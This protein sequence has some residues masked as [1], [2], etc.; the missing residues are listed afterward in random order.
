MHTCVTCTCTMYTYARRMLSYRYAHVRAHA[1]VHRRIR[2]ATRRLRSSPLDVVQAHSFWLHTRMYV[3]VYRRKCTIHCTV[4]KM[5]IS[6]SST[7]HRFYF[8][9]IIPRSPLKYCLYHCLSIIIYSIDL[10]SVEALFFSLVCM[11]CVRCVYDSLWNFE[12]LMVRWIEWNN[13][14]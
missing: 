1:L 6:D 14:K 11:I 12:N 4:Y 13:G 9:G 10:V 3:W 5:R 7:T 2:A 8:Y